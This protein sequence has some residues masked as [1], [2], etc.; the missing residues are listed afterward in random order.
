MD[1]T[2]PSL[3]KT[4][5]ALALSLFLYLV[6]PLLSYITMH[7]SYATLTRRHLLNQDL[8]EVLFA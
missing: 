8:S 5:Y 7:T 3:F 1:F 2:I 6:L 4:F